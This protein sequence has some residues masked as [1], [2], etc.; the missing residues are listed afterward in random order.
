MVGTVGAPKEAHIMTKE[1]QDKIAEMEAV[2]TS[3]QDK[4]AELKTVQVAAWPQ[5]GDKYHAVT[6]SGIVFSETWHG[7]SMDLDRKSLGAIFRTAGEVHRGVDRRKLI[8]E[9]KAFADFEPDWTGHSYKYFLAYDVVTRQWSHGKNSTLR[10][11]H[12]VYFKTRERAAEA[13]A[14]FD[15]RLYLLLED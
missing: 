6:S 7:D 14:R 1:Q 5:N 12:P 3:L 2:I 9:L 8:V 13:I 11:F 4:L 15:E 10:S